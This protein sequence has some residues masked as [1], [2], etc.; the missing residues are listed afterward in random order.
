MGF[1]QTTSKNFL[2]QLKGIKN[3]DDWKNKKREKYAFSRVWVEP[4]IP[5]N[6]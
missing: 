3:T 5:L 6:G 2:D 1:L 4:Y